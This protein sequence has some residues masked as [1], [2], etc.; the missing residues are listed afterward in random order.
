MLEDKA[1]S[2]LHMIRRAQR[3]RLKVYLGYAAGVGKTYQMLLEGHRLK[4]EGIDVVVGFVETH[5]RADTAKL[6]EGLDVVPRQKIE[7][8]GIT[9][10]ELDLK[11]VL[12]RKPQVAL[13]DEIAHTNVPGSG[14]AKRYEDIMDLLAAGIH[15][16]TTLNVQHL[17]S[18]YET[19]EKATGV[20]VRERLPDWVISEADQVVNVDLSIQDLQIRLEEGKVYPKERIETAM[21]H[22]F[23]PRNLDQ[24][25]ELTLRELV[26]QIDFRRR[27]SRLEE[28]TAAP[29]Q[30]MVCLSSRGPNPGSLVRYGY[31][32]A[33]K[34]N[35]N[36]YAVYIETAAEEATKIDAQTQRQLSETLELA[37]QLGAII[38]KYKGQDVVDTILQF[39]KEYLVGHIVIGRSAPK[40][41]WQ[42][43][44]RKQS[45]AERLICKAKGYTVVLVDTEPH[46]AEPGTEG[47]V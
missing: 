12:A 28:V 5:G 30:V 1:S 37:R 32:L 47:S 34:L 14:S 29:D 2:F 6:I 40:S 38:L 9:V 46:A 25:R 20:K 27:E 7:Y 22:F 31:R 10:E 41:F 39:A 36:W 43:I 44:L 15:V 33:G 18:L 24:L 8:H 3:G 45:V 23:T 13:I 17:E 42:R 35:R 21:A 4:A 19:V 26:S 11:A 16:I